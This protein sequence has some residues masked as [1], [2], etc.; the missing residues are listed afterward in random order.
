MVQLLE[1]G[2]QDDGTLSDVLNAVSDPIRRAILLR[3]RISG[4]RCSHFSDLASKTSLSYHFA[5]LRRAGLTDTRRSGTTKIIS[6]RSE[7]LETRYPGLIH[8]VLAATERDIS[9]TKERTQKKAATA[10]PGLPL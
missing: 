10:S 2:H 1:V 4:Q 9:P 3:L 5:F 8:A 6:L 7:A